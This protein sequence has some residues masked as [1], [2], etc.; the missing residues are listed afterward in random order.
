MKKTLN[1]VLYSLFTAFYAAFFSL[2]LACLLQL[3]GVALGVA[4]DGSA[5]IRQYPRLI[6]FCL[7]VGIICLIAL[8]ALGFLNA[9]FSKKLN[10]TKAVWIIQSACAAIVSVPMIMLWERLFEFLQKVF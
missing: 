2:G 8:I 5:V 1:F 7:I 4:I 6:P 3:L 9:K 10:Y